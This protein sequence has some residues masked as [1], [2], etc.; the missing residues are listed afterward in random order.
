MGQELVIPETPSQLATLD[1]E[2]SLT[3]WLIALLKGTL[4]G[5]IRE[6]Q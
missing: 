5:D 6:W 1:A 4:E 2:P 3:G